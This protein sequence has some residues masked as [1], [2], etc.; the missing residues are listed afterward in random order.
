MCVA[1]SVVNSSVRYWAHLRKACESVHTGRSDSKNR[2]TL[3]GYAN[4]L[5][6]CALAEL[7][8]L[9][10]A[11]KVPAINHAVWSDLSGSKRQA[12]PPV[13]LTE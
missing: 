11:G 4:E 5:Y 12:K 8:R 13:T 3:A 1:P 9:T 7:L 10:V 2:N 6:I